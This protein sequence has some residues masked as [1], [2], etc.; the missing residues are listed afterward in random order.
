MTRENILQQLS[1]LER[2]HHAY[3]CSRNLTLSSC[4]RIDGTKTAALVVIDE[5]LPVGLR[6]EILNICRQVQ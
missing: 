6:N 2:K 5:T 4:V 3:L 1:A